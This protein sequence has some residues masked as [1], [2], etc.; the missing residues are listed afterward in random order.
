[1]WEETVK[2]LEEEQQKQEKVITDAS[3][4]FEEISE[5]ASIGDF[6]FEVDI[7]NAKLSDVKK[8]GEKLNDNIA[9]MISGLDNTTR[10][11]DGNLSE[12]GKLTFSEKFIKVFSR[13]KAQEMRT[14]RISESDISENLN[15]LILQSDSIQNILIRQESL[16][17]TERDR[18]TVNY[19]R[20]LDLRQETVEELDSVRTKMLEIDPIIMGMQSELDVETSV[21][22]RTIIETKISE[23][24]EKLNVLKNE[25]SKL[26]SRSQ[27]LEK[28]IVQN[29]VHIQSL[30]S[31][32]TSQ[33][34][35]IDRLK[36]DTDQHLVLFKQYEVS[37]KTAQQQEAA[38]QLTEIGSKASK[39][40]M[41]GMAQ[42]GAATSNRLADALEN[43]AGEMIDVKEVARK[44]IE[45][46][47][48]F[49]R[50]FAHVLDDHDKGSYTD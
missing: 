22:E 18:G 47:D 29:K 1:M 9:R 21:T 25:E 13:D 3:I 11:I 14:T 16:L 8:S 28:Y 49:N 34:V 26:L 15:E 31:Q 41:V 32:L 36:T 10:G 35:L 43:H 17:V 38:H 5:K 7:E 27:S 39:G 44:Q 42:I 4:A 23:Q 12:M 50:R 30:E 20:T 48:R 37:L 19:K 46:H 45:S 6:E 24:Q 33:Q 40:A 2:Q